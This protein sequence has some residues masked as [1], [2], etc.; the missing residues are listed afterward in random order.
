MQ[1][2]DI[3]YFT[4]IHFENAFDSIDH[5]VL[6]KILKCYGT[7]QKI[8]SIIQQLYNDLPSNPCWDPDRIIL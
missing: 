3:L 8:I 7:S 5:L 1:M 4:F 6:W 2:A